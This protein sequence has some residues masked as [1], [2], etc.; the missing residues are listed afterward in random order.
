MITHYWSLWLIKAVSHSFN[1]C[2]VTLKWWCWGS[3]SH[4]LQFLT[5]WNVTTV[6]AIFN[7]ISLVPLMSTVMI[8]MS[9]HLWNVL[10]RLNELA[11]WW[12]SGVISRARGCAPVPTACFPSS[13]GRWQRWA[14]AAGRQ[15]RAPW[16]PLTPRSGGGSGLAVA[17]P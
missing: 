14:G 1:Y 9:K 16:R 17:R 6:I 12:H 5:K 2:T 10:H 13:A 4:T 15:H 8:L 3:V 11:S 7:V